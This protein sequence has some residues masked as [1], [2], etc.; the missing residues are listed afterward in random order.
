M[1]Y[2][3]SDVT[4]T[5]VN[6]PLTTTAKTP[7][8]PLPP[9]IPITAEIYQSIMK[10]RGLTPTDGAWISTTTAATS[11]TGAW[12]STDMAPGSTRSSWI[13][14][15]SASISTARTKVSE[16][17]LSTYSH[18][19]LNPMSTSMHGTQV[20]DSTLST[21]THGTGNPMSTS[22]HGTQISDSTLT[23]STHVTQIS[24][25]TP[26]HIAYTANV[27]T[28]CSDMDPSNIDA[29]NMLKKK[30][31]LTINH[32]SS[33]KRSKRCHGTHQGITS[34]TDYIEG[35]AHYNQQTF[36]TED[37]KPASVVEKLWQNNAEQHTSDRLGWVRR[38]SRK[39]GSSL[40]S[41]YSGDNVSTADARAIANACFDDFNDMT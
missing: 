37:K 24:E 13:S 6:R 21:S 38:S 40:S 9:L 23:T 11:T 8:P 27:P 39:I 26:T 41:S 14:T 33:P 16:C 4:M 19:T 31:G 22:M 29:V 17:T 10:A 30:S 3:A 25:P 12:V 34:H 2:Q 20:S 36:S 28:R 5:Q 15:D 7:L 32:H 18:G 1:N 35:R